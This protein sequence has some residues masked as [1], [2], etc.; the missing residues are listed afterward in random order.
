MFKIDVTNDAYQTQTLTLDDGTEIYVSLYFIP[1]QRMWVFETIQYEDIIINSTT[2]S[3]NPNILYQ[4]K[5]VLPFGIAC[6]SSDNRE[7]MFIDDFQQGRSNLYLL[8]KEEVKQY[9][10]ILKNG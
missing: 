1:M 5:N 9:E 4:F 2:I 8:T 7:P 3:N 6:K 10:E